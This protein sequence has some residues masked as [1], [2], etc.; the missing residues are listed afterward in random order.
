MVCVKYK[1]IVCMTA[2]IYHVGYDEML[3]TMQDSL[4]VLHCQNFIAAIRV[5]F[6]QKVCNIYSFS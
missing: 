4:V 1:L 2:L 3:K 5:K 6:T